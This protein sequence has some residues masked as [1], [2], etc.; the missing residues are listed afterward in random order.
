MGKKQNLADKFKIYTIIKNKIRIIYNHI[1]RT[2][3][4]VS[5]ILGLL[6]K[7]SLS[8]KEKR[9]LIVY[10]LSTQPFSIGDVL[11][12]QEAALV[13]RE[14]YEV[15]FVDF[16][17]IF[18]FEKP[19]KQEPA[20]SS[21]TENNVYYNLPP[22]LSAAQVNPY[23]GSLFVFNSHSQAY[24]YIVNNNDSYHVWPSAYKMA[25][26]DYCYFMIFNKLLYSYFE[27][28]NA[29]PVLTSRIFMHNWAAI[30]ISE[31]VYPDIPVT[32]NLRYNKLFSLHRNSKYESW[33]SFFDYCKNRFPVKFIIICSIN[34]IDERF[35]HLSNVII[36]KDY[37]TNTEQELSLIEIAE[38]HM[39]A[40][41]GMGTMALFG[42]KP[43]L[44]VNTDLDIEKYRGMIDEGDFLRFYFSTHLQKFAKGE[45]TSELLIDEFIKMWQTVDLVKSREEVISKKMAVTNEYT[46]LR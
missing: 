8:G 39:G 28:N 25:T 29:I 35:R 3:W 45:E 46:W 17:F 30:F 44:F 23:L 36:A 15:Q 1:R 43:F 13:L 2:K 40:S 16:A 4:I 19:A 10:D 32:I 5:W 9:L 38:I 18:N 26:R 7:D 22:L 33:L 11:V 34:E 20:F 14:Q 37:H 31:N 27:K 24:K 21:I 42:K 41:S 12:V 6:L